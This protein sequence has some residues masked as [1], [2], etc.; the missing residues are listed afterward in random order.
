MNQRLLA[1]V[2]GQTAQH[3]RSSEANTVSTAPAHASDQGQDVVD[4]GLG[5]G[6]VASGAQFA[7]VV[8]PSLASDMVMIESD[9]AVQ[10]VLEPMP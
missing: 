3:S 10:S 8:P 9:L 2:P 4:I 6:K 7:Q 5:P 1:S